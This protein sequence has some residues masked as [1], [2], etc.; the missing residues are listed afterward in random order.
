MRTIQIMTLSATLMFVAAGGAL[1]A[2]PISQQPVTRQ[3]TGKQSAIARQHATGVTESAN[4]ETEALNL[5][6]ANG[7]PDFKN[8]HRD[9]KNFEATVTQ[10]GKTRTVMVDPDARTV[11]SM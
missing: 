8:F 9:G 4:R 7:Y 11:K 10:N 5:L 2:A 6:G 3:G 1:A